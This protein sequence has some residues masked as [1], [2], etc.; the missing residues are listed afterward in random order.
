MGDL[1]SCQDVSLSVKFS[2]TDELQLG[3]PQA[4]VGD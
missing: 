1:M 3:D 2:T 4:G